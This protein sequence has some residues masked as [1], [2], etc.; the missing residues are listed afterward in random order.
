[1]EQNK[2]S[3]RGGARAGAGRPR[4][5]VDRVTIA[6]LLE[7]VERTT[8]QAYV[9]ILAE[10]FYSARANNDGHLTMKYHNL[11]LNKVAANLTAVEVTDSTDAMETKQ[12][13]FAA[14]L[15]AISQIK[16]TK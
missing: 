1:M 7:A 12:A 2:K 6:G 16:Q 11:I 13:A 4:G 15:A 5:T 14:A 10:D 3:G 9:D 8:G